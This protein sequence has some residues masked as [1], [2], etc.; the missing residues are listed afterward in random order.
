MFHA[1]DIPKS[2]QMMHLFVWRNYSKEKPIE[3][4]AI[5]AVNMGDRPFATNTHP[6]LKKTA[7]MEADTYPEVAQTVLKNSYM[8]DILGS[9]ESRQDA[10]SQMRDI[11]Q[12]LGAKDFHIKEWIHN[13]DNQESNAQPM[14]RSIMMNKETPSDGTELEGVLGLKW[15]TTTDLLS[16]QFNHCAQSSDGKVT[17]RKILSAANSIYDPTGFAT[18]FTTKIKILMRKAWA[19]KPKLSWDCQLPEEIFKQWKEIFMKIPLLSEM[20][21]ARSMTPPDTKGNPTLVIFSD[22]SEEA[23]GAVA[24]I[25]WELQDGTFHTEIIM[26]KSRVSPLNIIDIVRIELCGAVLGSRIRKTIQ[27]ELSFKFDKITHLVDSEIVHAMVNRDSYGYNTFAANRVGEIQ[28]NTSPEEWAWVPGKLNVSDMVTRGANPEEIGVGSEWQKGPKFLR[29]N[30]TNWP[31]K[32]EVSRTVTVPELKKVEQIAAPVRI[33][34]SLASRIDV[35]RFS[36]WKRLLM[37]TARI[38]KLYTKYKLPRSENFNH[39]LSKQDI[40]A[41]A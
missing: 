21:F 34:E 6:A 1:I 26:S 40:E 20:T 39:E 15:N 30:E 23:Y 17:K 10:L 19:H 32:Y 25:R 14:V 36:Q 9:N 37:V 18:P 8:D 2:D 27:K 29:E 16:L 7:E 5:A 22:G 3:T 11:E 41:A 12:V 28:Q 31:V 4:F 24:Y 13:I 33:S 38:L 35:R